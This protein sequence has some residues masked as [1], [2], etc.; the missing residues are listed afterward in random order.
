MHVES[1]RFFH[2]IA[3]GYVEPWRPESRAQNEVVM[4]I[5][6]DAAASYADAGYFT[7]IDGIV[8][9]RWFL[10]PLRDRLRARGHDVDYA[11]LR[12]PLEVCLER[13]AG[14]AEPAVLERL[15]HEFA[16][17]GELESHVVDAAELVASRAPGAW[18]GCRGAGE[19]STGRGRRR[20]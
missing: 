15:W 3:S 17:L 7:I 11:V 4:A 19:S 2:F 1:D 10:A 18:P 12:P 6:A 20:T 14:R 9:P 8:I 5:V 13:A 16:D